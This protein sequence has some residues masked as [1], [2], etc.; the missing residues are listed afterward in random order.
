MNASALEE[1]SDELVRHPDWLVQGTTL[2]ELIKRWKRYEN[3]DKRCEQL[4]RNRQ[5]ELHDTTV[6]IPQAQS[7]HPLQE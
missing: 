7:R 6:T 5:H 3:I 2:E 1:M 4:E